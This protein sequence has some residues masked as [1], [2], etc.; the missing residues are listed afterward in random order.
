MGT[1][2][3]V[4]GLTQIVVA[5]PPAARW[6]IVLVSE[7]YRESE[8]PL[9]ATDAQQFA[10]SLLASAP[11]DRLRAGINIYRVDV[12]STESGARDPTSC[13]HGTG[14]KPKTFFEAKFCTNGIRRLLTV[15]NGR[16]LDVVHK[17]LPQAHLILVAVNSTIAGGSGGNPGVFSRSAGSVEV[18]LHEMGHTAFGLADEYQYFENCQEKNHETHS[19]SEPGA[20]NITTKTDPAKIKWRHLIKPGTPIPTITNPNCKTCDF[21]PSPVPPGTIGLF[22][23]ADYFHCR[24]YRA[25]YDCRMRNVNQPFCAV[26]QEAIEK[27]L[28]PFLP[29]S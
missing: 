14:A 15:N 3:K 21:Q 27:K 22:E 20:P 12:T 7:G 28:T 23:G 16:V 29:P 9:F 24:A 4:L 19:S 25:E 17:L 10:D 26:C 5:G 11:F 1:N 6:N 13:E 8:M 18:A 2:G